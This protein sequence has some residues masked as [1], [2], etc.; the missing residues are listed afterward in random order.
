MNKKFLAIVCIVI[1]LILIICISH[2]KKSKNSGNT[3]AL[4]ISHFQS[5]TSSDDDSNTTSEDTDSD[6]EQFNLSVGDSATVREA[7]DV[8]FTL[9]EVGKDYIIVTTN[10]DLGTSL[11]ASESDVSSENNEFKIDENTILELYTL[12]TDV[13]GHFQVSY[14]STSK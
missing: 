14:A 9:K 3:I 12:T 10:V 6:L 7:E 11:V 13:V 1:V 4:T 5:Q 2:S 8:I